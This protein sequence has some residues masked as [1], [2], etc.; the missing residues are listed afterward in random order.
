MEKA[1][2]AVDAASTLLEIDDV[3]GGM[4]RAYYAMFYVAEALLCERSL[5]FSKHSGV[6]SAF[7]QHFAKTGELDPKFHQWLLAAFNKRIV[8]DYGVDVTF[9]KAEIE[10]AIAHARE[11]H[12][13][14]RRYLQTLP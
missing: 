3:E 8:A 12:A 13:A 14:A 1:E 6:H 2:R 5:S 4:S 7:G 10:E 9:A 11:F